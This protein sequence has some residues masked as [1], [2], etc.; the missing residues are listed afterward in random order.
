MTNCLL[1]LL[2]LLA[3]QAGVVWQRHVMTPKAGR[4]DLPEPHPLAYFTEYP[5]LRDEDGDFCYL[6]ALDKRLAEA[7]KR[8]V[9]TEVQLVGTLQ[10][11]EVYDLFYRFKC[12]GCP[13]WKSILV[14]TG[15]DQYR[16]IYHLQPTQVDSHAGASFIVNVGQDQLL[17]ARYNVGGNKGI[18]SDDHYWFHKSGPALVDFGPVRVAARA[19]LPDGKS[20][21]GG[22]DENGPRTLALAMFRFWVL[23]K[24]DWLCCGGGAVEVRFRLDQGRVIVTGTNYDPSARPWPENRKQ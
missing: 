10:G 23:D 18:Y 5:M 11:F 7:K 6:C 4:F 20:L 24:G 1:I 19:A 12:E 15:P 8:K 17:G 22:G 21:W 9:E 13:D 14:K 16:E 3:L 2:G